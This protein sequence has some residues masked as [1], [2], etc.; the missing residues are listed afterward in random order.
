MAKLKSVIIMQETA[1]KI[2]QKINQSIRKIGD[3]RIET[4]LNYG[5][6][7]KGLR[8]RPYLARLACE[9]VGGT[10]SEISQAAVAIELM[11]FSTLIMDDIFDEAPKRGGVETVYEKFGRDE[12]IIT[13]EILKSLAMSM[14]LDVCTNTKEVDK[15]ALCQIF[16]KAYRDIY[17]GQYLDLYFETKKNVSEDDY[18]KMI[19][20]TTGSLIKTSTVTG[21]ILG[22]G[23]ENEIALL[24]KYGEFTGYA[25]QIRDDLVELIGQEE[26][27]GKKIGG[28]IYRRKKRLPVIYFLHK[29]KDRKVRRRFWRLLD[30]L[31]SHSELMGEI[32]ELLAKAGALEYC[33]QKINELCDKAISVVVNSNFKDKNAT[34]LLREFTELLRL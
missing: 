28:D 15:E 2:D 34:K 29:T 5:L 8:E 31:D 24:G 25:F 1:R 14:L 33:R 27:I 18:L 11:H 17:I 4:L 23:E 32:I 22:G 6:S 12:A 3:E 9:A 30:K 7:P 26:M 19:Y 16:E 13:A 20:R 10:F 21:A